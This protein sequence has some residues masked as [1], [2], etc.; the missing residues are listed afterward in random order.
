VK[1]KGCKRQPLFASAT[2][3]TS[4]PGNFFWSQHAGVVASPL[5]RNEPPGNWKNEAREISGYAGAASEHIQLHTL[6]LRQNERP[7]GNHSLQSTGEL[8]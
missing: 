8:S 4:I 7:R 2:E 3:P 1:P 6:S 5:L